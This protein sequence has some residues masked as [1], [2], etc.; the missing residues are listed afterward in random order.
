VEDG[1][2]AV[3]GRDDFEG[4]LAILLVEVAHVRFG[5]QGENRML[6]GRGVI[7]RNHVRNVEDEEVFLRVSVGEQGHDEDIAQIRAIRNPKFAPSGTDQHSRLSE[8]RFA[9][10]GTQIRA[11]RNPVDSFRDQRQ[12]VS[13]TFEAGN[14]LRR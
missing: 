10:F 12:G 9:P 7:L 4:I 3:A 14:I 11:F 5:R 13:A 6:H 1:R 2:Q 8:P